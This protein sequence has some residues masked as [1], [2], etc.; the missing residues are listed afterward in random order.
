[1]RV[2]RSRGAYAVKPCRSMCHRARRSHVGCDCTTDQCDTAAL[3]GGESDSARGRTNTGSSSL[4]I[5][6]WDG[7][8][9]PLPGASGVPRTW[10]PCVSHGSQKPKCLILLGKHPC[11]NRTSTPCTVGRIALCMCL[12]R[13]V[14]TGSHDPA[15]HQ[16]RFWLPPPDHAG[17]TPASKVPAPAQA[18]PVRGG[19]AGRE[20]RAAYF[21][22]TATH[23]KQYIDGAVLH[24]PRNDALASPSQHSR[25]TMDRDQRCL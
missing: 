17:T 10:L 2:M 18:V 24:G 21:A 19:C 20:H 9:A 22:A 23:F 11:G 1:M 8:P 7:L 25:Y 4:A 6:F 3:P 5:A 16:G 15:V 14:V 13:A 12:K